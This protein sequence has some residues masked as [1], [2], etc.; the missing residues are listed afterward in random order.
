[1]SA[2]SNLLVNVVFGTPNGNFNGNASSFFSNSIKGDGYFGYADGLH[3]AAY[4]TTNLL[5]VITLQASLIAEPGT[6]DWF[7]VTGTTFGSASTPT[8]MQQNFNFTGNFVWIRTKITN[9]TAGSIGKITVV[10]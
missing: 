10:Q 9:F 4:F 3:T 8:S 7:D 1:M 5:G 6:N 2:A